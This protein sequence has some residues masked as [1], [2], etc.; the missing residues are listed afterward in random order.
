MLEELKVEEVDRASSET[1]GGARRLALETVALASNQE[2]AEAGHHPALINKHVKATNCWAQASLGEL[3][4][5]LEGAIVYT[6]CHR[7][8]SW[9]QTVQACRHH[10][11]A[12]TWLASESLRLHT[13]PRR[14]H[15]TTFTG[16]A[17]QGI[18]PHASGCG[19]IS[20]SSSS[21]CSATF[22]YECD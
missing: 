18:G 4:L 17:T 19:T 11:R 22:S 9:Q 15:R 2:G 6:T 14:Y 3:N 21:L 10:S 8:G 12:P 20:S 7:P 16:L 5:L 1:G 13:H